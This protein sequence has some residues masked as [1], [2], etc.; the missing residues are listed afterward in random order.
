MNYLNK[1][2]G[3]NKAQ[4]N[5]SSDKNPNRVAGG[6]R[7][8]GVDMFEMLGEDGN[9]QKIPTEAYV[10]SLEEQL[11]KQRTAINVLEKRVSRQ[12]KTLDSLDAYVRTK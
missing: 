12:T 9:V 5:Q 10:R 3:R 2:Y 4:Q 8:Q 11:R 6:L 1:M 7:A